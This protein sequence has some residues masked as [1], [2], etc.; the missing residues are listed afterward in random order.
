MDCTAG[1][2]TTKATRLVW[3]AMPWTFTSVEQQATGQDQGKLA[4]QRPGDGG[5]DVLT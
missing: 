4:T 2:R 3:S 5:A 1:V